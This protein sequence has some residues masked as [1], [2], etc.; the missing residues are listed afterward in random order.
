MNLGNVI[1]QVARRREYGVLALLILAVLTV[2]AVNPAFLAAG[3]L[4]NILVQCHLRDT[5]TY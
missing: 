3:N 4:R 5:F 2:T 1:G